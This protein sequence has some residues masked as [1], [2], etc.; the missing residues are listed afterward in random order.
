[1]AAPAAITAGVVLVS[2]HDVV[3]LLGTVGFPSH[4]THPRCV[5]PDICEGTHAV[6][7]PKPARKRLW[8][9]TRKWT[10]RGTR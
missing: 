8:Q 9:P 10:R 4:C 6:P 1:M 3:R 2:S 7:N 5:A